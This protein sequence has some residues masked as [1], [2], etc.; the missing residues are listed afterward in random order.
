MRKTKIVLHNSTY[1]FSS[2]NLASPKS[3]FSS[4]C[5][6]IQIYTKH[7]NLHIDIERCTQKAAVVPPTMA[8]MSERV[9]CKK[10]RKRRKP[11]KE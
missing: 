2:P 5:T 3:M 11:T 1:F 6:N 4:P 10:Q 9:A 8:A 7:S